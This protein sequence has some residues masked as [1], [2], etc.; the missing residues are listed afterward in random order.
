M[1]RGTFREPAAAGRLHAQ[2]VLMRRAERARIVECLSNQWQL[3]AGCEHSGTADNGCPLEGEHR[4]R[5]DCGLS[6]RRQSRPV[7]LDGALRAREKEL[8]RLLRNA[9]YR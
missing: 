2:V 7:V 9:Q 5:R 4:G 3:R 1:D 8:H 6:L